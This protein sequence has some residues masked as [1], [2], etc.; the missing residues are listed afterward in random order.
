MCDPLWFYFQ[1]CQYIFG[2][3]RFQK[4][5]SYFTFKIIVLSDARYDSSDN[6]HFSVY[7][8]PGDLYLLLV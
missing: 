4:L 7:I 6:P 1:F 5:L 8:G 3:E 2:L